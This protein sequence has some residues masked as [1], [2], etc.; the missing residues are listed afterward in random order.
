VFRETVRDWLDAS[1]PAPWS[2]DEVLRKT[3][4]H[5]LGHLFGLTHDNGMIMSQGHTGELCFHPEDIHKIR[6]RSEGPGPGGP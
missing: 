3:T 4:V 6:E 2:V 5:E 1:D